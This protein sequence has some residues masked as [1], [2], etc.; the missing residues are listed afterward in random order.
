MLG[1]RTTTTLNQGLQS[2]ID[3]IARTG[4]REFVYNLPLDIINEHTPTTW[5]DRIM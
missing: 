1:Y 5:V 4:P 2:T 3:W